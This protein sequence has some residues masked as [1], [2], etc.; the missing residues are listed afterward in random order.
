MNT[1]N[2]DVFRNLLLLT[3]Q[4][5]QFLSTVSTYNALKIQHISK[6]VDIFST[7]KAKPCENSTCCCINFATLDSTELPNGKLINYFDSSK[8][9]FDKSEHGISENIRSVCSK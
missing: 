9:C 8:F 7:F 2:Q 1:I 4:D 3:S 5:C 6:L